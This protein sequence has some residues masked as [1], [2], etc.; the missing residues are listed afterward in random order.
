V[1]CAPWALWADSFALDIAEDA[2]D[3]TL[4]TTEL[5]DDNA[6]E[7]LLEA[8]A[9]DWDADWV[10]WRI[11][12]VADLE[13]WAADCWACCV[14]CRIDSDACL[15]ESAACWLACRTAWSALFWICWQSFCRMRS[16]GA[17]VMIAASSSNTVRISIVCDGCGHIEV[18]NESNSCCWSIRFLWETPD[19]SGFIRWITVLRPALDCFVQQQLMKVHTEIECTSRPVE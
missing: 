16:S 5:A 13:A 11:A 15:T 6:C 17:G 18:L 12:S 14:T 2:D 10:A 1:D 4:A 8:S 9:M 7:A 19:S 3:C